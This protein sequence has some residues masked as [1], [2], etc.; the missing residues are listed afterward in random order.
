MAIFVD[1]E[2][3]RKFISQAV[4]DLPALPAVA[5]RI[6][7]LSQNP[8]LTASELDEVISCDPAMSA[9]ILRVVNSP[10]YGLSRQV[11][12]TAHAIV[13]LGTR[14]V[15]NLALSMSA[16]NVIGDQKSFWRH[17]YGAA[18]AVAELADMRSV[19]SE[20]KDAAVAGALLHDVGLL[21]L[22]NNFI[23]LHRLAVEN[24]RVNQVTLDEAE[25]DL[26]GI[27][28]AEV[29][30]LLTVNWHFPEG[31]CEL[32]RNHSGPFDK[33]DFRLALVHAADCLASHAGFPSVP[34]EE[35]VL[36]A[37]VIGQLELSDDEMLTVI[38]AVREKVLNAEGPLFPEAA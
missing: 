24:A 11:T 3:L 13:I 31:L 7:V 8:D 15:Q 18:A 36:D 16:M 37:S 38:E 9:K 33:G 20:D 4:R 32:I 25:R 30:E 19:T 6:V 12:T 10:Y 23:D 22:K 35:M 17:S 34:G 27:T 14:Q 28:H 1:K 21:F 5:E 29:G 26:L 2:A